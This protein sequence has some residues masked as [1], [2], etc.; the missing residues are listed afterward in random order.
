VDR[1]RFMGIIIQERYGLILALMLV[2]Y[3]LD[4]LDT[5]ALVRLINAFVWSALLFVALWAPGIPTRLRLIGAIFTV[6][7]LSVG[8]ILAFSDN[9]T[10]RIVLF[11]LLAT[12]QALAM[13]AIV[14][15]VAHHERV[16][17]QTVMGAIAGYVLLGLSLGALYQGLDLA[18]ATPL[19]NNIDNEGDYVY[20]SLITLTTVGY[21]DITPAAEIAKRLVSVEALVGQMFLVTLVARLVTLWGRPLRSGAPQD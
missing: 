20:F 18:T 12:V 10:A 5:G 11:L 21:G 19:F 3:V 6:A 15:R 14:V 7:L 4:G 9:E 2:G 1:Q 16:G 13:V 17:P 8:L